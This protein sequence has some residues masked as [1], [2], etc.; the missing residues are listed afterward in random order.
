MVS[1]LGLVTVQTNN[2]LRREEQ[3]ELQAQQEARKRQ[4]QP[5]LAG[6]AH[7]IRNL[8]DASKTAKS[9]VEQ[10]MLTDL[11]NRRGEYSSAKLA[12]IRKQG[13]AEIFMMLGEEKASAITAWLK[14]I[15]F[16]NASAKIWGTKTTPVPELNPAQKA[17]VV[18]QVIQEAQGEMRAMVEAELRAGLIS[19]KQ[20]TDRLAVAMM[21]RMEELAGEVQEAEQEV[22]NKAETRIE[23]KLDDVLVESDFNKVLGLLIDDLN[24][25]KSVVLKGPFQKVKKCLVWTQAPGQGPME[26]PAK[27][28]LGNGM[29]GG[30]M[31]MAVGGAPQLPAPGQQGPP[32]Q[33]Q[34]PVSVQDKLVWAFDRV[35]PLD[36]Y[37]LPD[38]EDLKQG[39]FH[40]HRLTKSDLYNMRKTK[41]FDKKA[42]DLVLVDYAAGALDWLNVGIDYQRHSL[43]DRPDEWRKTGG[44]IDA[45]QYWGEIQGLQLLQNGMDPALV[46]DPLAMYRCEVWLI[47]KVIIKAELNGDPLGEVPYQKTS[48]R[49]NNGSFWG[50]S[51]LGLFRDSIDACNATARNMLNNAAI[52]SGPQVGIDYSQI[53][54]GDQVTAMYPWK[55]WAF[56]GASPGAMANR[57]PLKFFAPPSVVNELI[58]LYEFF[59]GQADEKTGVPKY[60]YGSNEKGGPLDTARGFTMM[61]NSVARGIKDVVRNLD[62]DI[63]APSIIKLYQNQLLYSNDPEWFQSDLKIVAQGSISLVMKEAA[64]LR[65]NEFLAMAANPLTLKIIGVEGYAEILRSVAE[66]LDL[67]SGNIVPT[68]EAVQRKIKTEELNQIIS[69]AEHQTK[70]IKSGQEPDTPQKQEGMSA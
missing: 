58:K 7:F 37:P 31:G 45:L 67:P 59:S 62:Q 9:K 6:L 30:A 65:R 27:M 3:A 52:A 35:S 50:K 14:D 69:M 56:D 70:R 36:I 68:K 8:W 10:E 11:R 20:A 17:R 23:N 25:Y 46:E 66:G 29:P 63:I 54:E 13:G 18:Q 32:Q 22:A 1:A 48:F 4:A 44:K 61:M 16:G 19:E 42:I 40:R 12:E 26:S 24:T 49:R 57:D 47:D 64:A 51:S 39:F 21:E 43:E 38:A 34:R 2:D 53:R 33:P 60:A 41:G 15:F 5:E 55:L 28:P